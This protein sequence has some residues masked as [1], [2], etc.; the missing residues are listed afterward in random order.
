MGSYPDGASPYGLLDMAGNVREWTATKWQKE[1][2][3]QVEDEWTDAY[4]AGDDWRVLRGGSWGSE[5][6]FV[7]GA[8][9]N[10]TASRATATSPFGLRLARYSLPP[11][12]GDE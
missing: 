6:Q 12:D 7:R 3:Y 11:T 2:P 4:L 1:Y 5:Q 10:V 8:S 9:R